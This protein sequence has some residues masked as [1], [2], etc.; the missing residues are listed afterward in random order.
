MPKGY[1]RYYGLNDGWH[2]QASCRGLAHKDG[3]Y[4]QAWIKPGV[5]YTDA[6]GHTTPGHQVLELALMMCAGCPAQWEC[7]RFA[8]AAD[9]GHEVIRSMNIH[10]FAWLRSQRNAEAIITQAERRRIPVQFAVEGKLRAR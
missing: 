2:A 3:I 7:A 5:P 9:D 10:H 1:T 6:E 4:G 8:L